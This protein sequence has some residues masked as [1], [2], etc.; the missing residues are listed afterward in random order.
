MA[1]LKIGK[2]SHE[3]FKKSYYII[4]TFSLTLNIEKFY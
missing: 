1:T 2:Q 3:I 4:C